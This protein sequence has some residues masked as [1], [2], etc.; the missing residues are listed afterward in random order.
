MR[1]AL[2]DVERLIE[3]TKQQHRDHFERLRALGG[4]ASEDGYDP[5]SVWSAQEPSGRLVLVDL[6]VAR[7]NLLVALASMK[8]R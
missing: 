5:E 7:A 8:R 4:Y 3:T 2:R 6:I 1:A